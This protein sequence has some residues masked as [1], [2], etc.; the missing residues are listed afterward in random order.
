[1]M[2]FKCSR[3]NDLIADIV[4]YLVEHG[5]DI[6]KPNFNGGTCL[7]N[8]V[9]SVELC[10]FLLKHGAD[11]NAGDAQNKTPLYYAIQEHRF[12]TMK[13]LLD[14]N[15]DPYAKSWSGE[16]ALQTACLKGATQIFDYLG[17]FMQNLFKSFSHYFAI[18][19]SCINF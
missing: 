7:I 16:D 18:F 15:A 6:L 5:A 9:Q 10:T 12:E 8:S 13:L 17:K 1:M 3:F 14:H 2:R 19:F 4:E 11:V